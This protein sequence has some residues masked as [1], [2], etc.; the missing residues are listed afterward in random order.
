LAG[1]FILSLILASR[2]MNSGK[3]CDFMTIS[4][5]S[6]GNEF[7]RGMNT[8]DSSLASVSAFTLSMT[9]II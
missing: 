2:A 6:G 4:R 3:M 5:C 9:V 1:F 7:E 8:F